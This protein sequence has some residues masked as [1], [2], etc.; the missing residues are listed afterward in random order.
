MRA[1]GGVP[2]PLCSQA[3]T[4]LTCQVFGLDGSKSV[5]TLSWYS[6]TG[7]LKVTIVKNERSAPKQTEKK[8]LL[9][10]V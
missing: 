6:C 4:P 2:A 5:V 7:V 9:V 10:S 3:P 8:Y 1:I